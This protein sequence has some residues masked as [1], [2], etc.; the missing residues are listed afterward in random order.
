MNG[1]CETT[2]QI[3]CN[4]PTLPHVSLTPARFGQERARVVI[5]SES[6]SIPPAAPGSVCECNSY[7]HGI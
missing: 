6:R 1:G 4:L 2:E 5:N 3:R 7:R